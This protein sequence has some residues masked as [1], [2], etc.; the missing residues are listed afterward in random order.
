[1]APADRHLAETGSLLSKGSEPEGGEG[2][3]VACAT[4]SMLELSHAP[5]P[6]P[7]CL[8]APARLSAR[9]FARGAVPA[10]GRAPSPRRGGRP[11]NRARPSRGGAAM[12]AAGFSN[13][14]IHRA[15][16]ARRRSLATSSDNVAPSQNYLPKVHLR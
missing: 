3:G 12:T 16:P 9:T 15:C 13:D 2:G 5:P 6:P 11:G 14:R 1:M 8:R 10:S 7:R 4:C